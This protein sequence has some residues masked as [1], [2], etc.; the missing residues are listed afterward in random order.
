M[1]NSSEHDSLS[2]Y[3]NDMQG[4]ENIPN[5]PATE[6]V[7][8]A[9]KLFA[10][11]FPLQSSKIQQSILE[12]LVTS[13]STTNAHRDPARRAAMTVNVAVAV[14]AALKV[15]ARD[16]ACDPGNIKGPEVERPFQELLHVC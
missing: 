14:L 1:C 6:V 13:L 12:Q 9:I 7:N 11:A 16:T 2:L 4:T 15:A 10:V 8:A 3:L 5:P